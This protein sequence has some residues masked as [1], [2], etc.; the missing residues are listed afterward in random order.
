MA[1]DQADAHAQQEP[2]RPNPDLEN[3]DRLVG[4][5]NVTGATALPGDGCIPVAADTTRP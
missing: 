5:W 2:P 4:E 3:L 1:D